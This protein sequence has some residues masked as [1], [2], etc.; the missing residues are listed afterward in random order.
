V[1]DFPEKIVSV[2]KLET[3]IIIKCGI[4]RIDA[5]L[6][7]QQQQPQHYWTPVD[8]IE[9]DHVAWCVRPPA[10]PLIAVASP[11]TPMRAKIVDL[12]RSS[13]AW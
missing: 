4:R 12:Y 6:R 11:I 10:S 1:Y 13:P 3:E 5:V 9:S 2:D 7:V 8:K